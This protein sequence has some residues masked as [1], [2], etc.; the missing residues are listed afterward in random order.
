MLWF[1]H[2]LFPSLAYAA[3]NDLFTVKTGA[4]AQGGCSDDQI[5]AIEPIFT[6]AANII[7]TAVKAFENY[8][9]DLQVRKIALMFFGIQMNDQNAGPKDQENID[10]LQSV[11][12]NES[13]FIE[14]NKKH[15]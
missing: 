13:E 15:N 2:L 8:Q 10:R 4:N 12:G 6:E 9:N 5:K 7:D 11:N 3:F 1:Y 14:S